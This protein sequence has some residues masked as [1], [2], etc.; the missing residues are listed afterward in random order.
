A[1][2]PGEIQAIY[3]AGAAG[4]CKLRCHVRWDS[5]FCKNQNTITVPVTVCNDT[6]SAAPFHLSFS[7]LPA[8]SGCHIPGPTSFTV[9]GPNPVNVPAYSCVT[10]NVS[11]ARPSGMNAAFLVACYEVTITNQG[12]GDVSTCRGS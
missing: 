12:T 10:V 3:N 6:G 11:I 8:G 4:K 9:I 1:L 7:G 2:T 5:P